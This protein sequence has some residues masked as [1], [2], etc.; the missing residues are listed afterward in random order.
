MAAA[1]GVK[2]VIVETSSPQ[3]ISA[4][5]ANRVDVGIA[6]TTATPERAE[7]VAFS[8]PYMVYKHIVLVREDSD[9]KTFEDL[10]GHL[11]A[12]VRDTTPELE[13]L[14]H[15]ETWFE[16]CDYE[17]YGSDSEQTLALRQGKADAVST[18]SA[19]AATLVASPQVEGLTVCCNVPGFTDWTGIIVNRTASNPSRPAASRWM[20]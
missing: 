20:V 6:S 19:Y 2:A 8:V 10:P 4:L 3:R 11:M 9:I 1:L 14:K 7:T 12:T 15:C 13:Y 16:G 18:S 5:V 17:S